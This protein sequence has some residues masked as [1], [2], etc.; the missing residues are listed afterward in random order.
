MQSAGSPRNMACMQDEENSKTT[1]RE[2]TSSKTRDGASAFTRDGKPAGSAEP[3]TWTVAISDGQPRGLIIHGVP[4]GVMTNG[5]IDLVCLSRAHI[6]PG[7][8]ETISEVRKKYW[9]NPRGHVKYD[10]FSPVTQACIHAVTYG[11][12][13]TELAGVAGGI[14]TIAA[15]SPASGFDAQQRVLSKM[16]ADAAKM[17]GVKVVDWRDCVNGLKLKPE[18]IL[19]H[20][21]GGLAGSRQAA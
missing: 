16:L 19:C 21:N 20:Q 3:V 15:D 1:S 12:G 8:C 9:K 17:D 6:K 5:K 13:M 4:V 10:E 7:D 14:V 18:A 2:T 11:W